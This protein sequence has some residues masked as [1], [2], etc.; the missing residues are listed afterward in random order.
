M[1]KRHLVNEDDPQYVYMLKYEVNVQKV[2]SRTDP[3]KTFANPV[4]CP[5]LYYLIKEAYH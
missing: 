5:G 3:M 4:L 2:I 1:F